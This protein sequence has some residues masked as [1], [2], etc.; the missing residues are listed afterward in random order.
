MADRYCDRCGGTA[1]QTGGCDIEWCPS[2]PAQYLE[3][4][5]S[6]WGR[7][8]SVVLANGCFDPF[9]Y[10]HLCYLQEARKLGDV[11]IVAVTVD[12]QV[13]KGPGR[14]AFPLEER[15][16]IIRALAIVDMVIP[17]VSGLEAVKKIKPDVFVKGTE[18][19]GKLQ[20]KALVEFYGGRV[21]FTDTPTYSSTAI[22]TGLH[23]Q[24]QGARC[25]G[26]DN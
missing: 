14:P 16:A 3:Q 26:R 12:D 25:R 24:L 15:M 2:W 9:H 11:L 17:S 8:K 7:K 19:E 1:P 18:Y 23:L 6:F 5:P 10:G 22:L 20:E 21:V 13:N 4:H